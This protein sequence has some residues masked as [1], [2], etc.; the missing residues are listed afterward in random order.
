MLAVAR[1]HVPDG[2]D[3]DEQADADEG[4]GEHDAHLVEDEADNKGV[5]DGGDVEGLRCPSI[6]AQA[7]PSKQGA[8]GGD[9][10][11]ED[12]DPLGHALRAHCDDERAHERDERGD[13]AQHGKSR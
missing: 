7:D 2:V 1:V 9:S 6:N 3:G 5:A 10:G 8:S 11:G 12:A 13:E 4:R